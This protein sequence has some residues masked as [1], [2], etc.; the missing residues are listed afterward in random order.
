MLHA[1]GDQTIAYGG[2]TKK[3]KEIDGGILEEEKR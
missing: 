3:T 2:S 1:F